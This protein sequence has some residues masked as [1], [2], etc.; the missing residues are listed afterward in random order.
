[1]PLPFNRS[2][3]ASGNQKSPKMHICPVGVEITA[4]DTQVL[5]DDPKRSQYAMLNRCTHE[6]SRGSTNHKDQQVIDSDLIIRSVKRESTVPGAI[7]NRAPPESTP[8]E[9][10][11][12]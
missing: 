9:A 5:S 3:R 8:R 2:I 4:P 7:G 11:P 10:G 1:M 6:S 12:S